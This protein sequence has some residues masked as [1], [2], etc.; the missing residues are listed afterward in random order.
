MLLSLI[1]LIIFVL[2][3]LI[4]F[5]LVR[6]MSHPTFVTTQQTID[7]EGQK[8]YLNEFLKLPKKDYILRSFDGYELHC[9]LLPNDP[10][11]NKVVII[12]H[13]H[14]YTKWGSAKYAMMFHK[15]GYHAVIYDNRGH[16]EN[17]SHPVTM[18]YYEKKDLLC[19]IN[20]TKN[21]IGHNC[22]MGLHG[23]SMGSAISLQVLEF[24]PDI[25][26]IVS[27]CGYSDLTYFTKMAMTTHFHLPVLLLHTSNLLNKILTGYWLKEVSPISNLINNTVPVCFIH[28]D[29]DNLVDCSNATRMY[30]TNNGYK[31]LHIFKNT[32]HAKSFEND[33]DKYFHIVQNFLQNINSI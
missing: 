11:S 33:Q 4:S 14:S 8:G 28:G 29:S 12:T 31:E 24:N 23:E 9:T 3:F 30:D 1:I 10:S 18:G 17:K 22:Y 25:Q 6:R 19:V 27:D 13:G 32:G 5:L 2:I 15:L 16:G 7:R 21:K 26:F 20:D